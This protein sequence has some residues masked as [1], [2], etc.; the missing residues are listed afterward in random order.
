MNP[1]NDLPWIIILFVLKDYQIA[2]MGTSLFPISIKSLST[3]YIYLGY[4]FG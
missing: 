4:F 1:K 3:Y 2:S